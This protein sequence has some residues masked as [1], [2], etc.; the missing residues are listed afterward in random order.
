[1][2]KTRALQLQ[3]C[4]SRMQH[5]LRLTLCSTQIPSDSTYLTLWHQEVAIICTYNDVQFKIYTRIIQNSS[6]RPLSSTSIDHNYDYPNKVA[7]FIPF[8]RRSGL[9]KKR[10]CSRK[11]LYLQP[12]VTCSLMHWTWKSPLTKS[13]FTRTNLAIS[14]FIS[15][16]PSR[17]TQSFIT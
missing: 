14:G 11:T 6:R 4:P 10:S 7:W 3:Y 17:A 16:S 9:S 8:C 2:N 13:G 5:W 12:F 15:Y 1:M